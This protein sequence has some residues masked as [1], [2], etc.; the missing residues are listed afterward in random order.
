MSQNRVSEVRTSQ[1]ELGQERRIF[2]FK[3]SQWI[4]LGLGI[5]EALI[6]LRVVLKLIAANPNSPFASFVYNLSAIFLLPFADL[7]G[8]PTSGGMVLE[9]SSIIAMI[10][11]ALLAWGIERIVWVIF[12]RPS[13][14]LI[15]GKGT[16]TTT[17]EN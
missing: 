1:R 8:T 3:L 4:W 17:H 14:S 15:G 2:S 12:D 16:Q 7:V 5:V 11:Y 13:E 9:L 6:A 10:V